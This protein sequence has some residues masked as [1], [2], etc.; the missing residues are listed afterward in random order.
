MTKVDRFVNP[1]YN[2]SM[3]K[4]I[5]FDIDG[6][7]VN[8]GSQS[9]SKPVTE[10]LRK[11]QEKGIKLFLATGRPNF[12][13]PKFEGI[14]FDGALAFNGA[15]C[16]D[17]NNVLYKNPIP[18]DELIK[19]RK[20]AEKINKSIAYASTDQ[21]V[22]DYYQDNL[23]RYFKMAGQSCP[24]SKD[25]NEFLEKDV[26]QMM[27][28]TTSTED[29]A[30]LEGIQNLKSVRWVDFA[31]DI[32]PSNGGKEVAIQKILSYYGFKQ[33]ETM[34]FGDGGNDAEMLRYAHIGVAM[35]NAMPE[36]KEAANY[37]TKDV[38]DDGIIHALKVF[39]LI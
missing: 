16:F 25:I 33:E 11:L 9:I 13:I 5:F 2:M 34:A 31:T 3:I 14:Q 28:A 15:Y 24:P 19:I 30:L 21:M 4:I 32:I 37:I 7:L 17:Q 20:N 6:T 12:V 8:Y 23:D 10:A 36:A 27:V 22:C 38:K 35:D 18:K 1:I 26:Y 29:P 39:D